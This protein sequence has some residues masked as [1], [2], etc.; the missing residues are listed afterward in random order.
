MD[1]EH[2]H[3][4]RYL[5]DTDSIANGDA[6]IPDTNAHSYAAYTNSDALTD[7]DP[8]TDA[9]AYTHADA[10][11]YTHSNPNS[12]TG[13]AGPQPLDKDASSDRRQRRHRRVHH[14]RNRSQACA[15]SGYWTFHNGSSW[16]VG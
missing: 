16:C 4:H 3:D 15:A 8:Y 14:L 12:N 6:G 9:D 1:A 7:A 13:S 10:D 2:Q 11:A 5:R